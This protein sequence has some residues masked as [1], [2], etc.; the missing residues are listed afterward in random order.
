ML[1]VPRQLQATDDRLQIRWWWHTVTVPVDQVTAVNHGRYHLVLKTTTGISL[2]FDL[3]Q[4]CAPTTDL[5]GR[6]CP[7]G[8]LSSAWPACSTL[9]ISLT[10]A[11]RAADCGGMAAIFAIVGGLLLWLNV[12]GINGEPPAYDLYKWLWVSS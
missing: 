8:G 7:N 11:D 12:R 3:S 5:A 10:P 4:P 9:P 6:L 1:T 2:L